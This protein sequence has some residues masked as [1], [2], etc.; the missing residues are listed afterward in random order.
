MDKIENLAYGH[1]MAFQWYT[2]KNNYFQI[3]YIVVNIITIL[4]V[5]AVLQNADTNTIRYICL[6]AVILAHMIRI[7]QSKFSY[8]EKAARHKFAY[9]RL[10]STIRTRGETDVLKD[11][12]SIQSISPPLPPFLLYEFISSTSTSHLRGNSMIQPSRRFYEDMYSIYRDAVEIIPTARYKGGLVNFVSNTIR[13]EP[14]IPIS[15]AMR[16]TRNE[17]KIDTKEDAIQA[18][19]ELLK[20]V[21]TLSYSHYLNS[22]YYNTKYFMINIP[23][24]FCNGLAILFNV[25]RGDD[26]IVFAIVTA[27]DSIMGVLEEKLKFKSLSHLHETATDAFT[28]LADDIYYRILSK[29]SNYDKIQQSISLFHSIQSSSPTISG[30]ILEYM[31]ERQHRKRCSCLFMDL[32]LFCRNFG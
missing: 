10:Q 27:I 4:S 17:F 15:I 1:R 6:T 32:V 11:I 23:A 20:R 16:H 30:Y 12:K 8:T 7:F 5:F 13:E 21:A 24:T 25:M 18:D 19:I 2:R 9:M 22:I 26:P 28:V 29:E 14:V 3:P 31:H